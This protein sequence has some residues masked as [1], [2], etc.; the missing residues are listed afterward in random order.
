MQWTSPYGWRAAAQICPSA[1]VLPLTAPRSSPDSTTNAGHPTSV[2]TPQLGDLAWPVAEQGAHNWPCLCLCLSVQVQVP[3]GRRPPRIELAPSPRA[4]VAGEGP[5]RVD[6]ESSPGLNE[7]W[8]RKGSISP[9]LPLAG[10]LGPR[11]V[12]GFSPG[13]RARHGP[14]EL[15]SGASRVPHWKSRWLVR[16]AARKEAPPR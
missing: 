7:F 9:S 15:A 4:A 14:L 12:H 3:L 5:D 8:E 16:R 2:H 13:Y 11:P 10:F 1:V 6:G